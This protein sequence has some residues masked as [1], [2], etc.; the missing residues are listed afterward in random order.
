MAGRPLPPL[1]PQQKR[2]VLIGSYLDSYRRGGF[3]VTPQEV[4]RQVV[5]DCE[6]VD[7]AERAGELRGGGTPDPTPPKPRPD[8]IREAEQ[9]HGVRLLREGDAPPQLWRPGFMYRNPQAVGERWGYAV[10]RIA[11]IME[12][13]T[14][15][16]A[17]AELAR[18]YK[19]VFACFQLRGV[20]PEKRG[21][22]INQFDGL[23]DRDAARAFM[24]AV[25][26]I[27]DRSTGVLGSWYVK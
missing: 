17:L 24:R 12:G 11:R 3:K 26:D 20:A 14:K 21:F 25:E 9:Q 2:D 13:G 16:G 22:R 23:T 1:T 10:A 19:T 6:L 4:E 15:E 27:C 18:A 5:A 7:A 8:P